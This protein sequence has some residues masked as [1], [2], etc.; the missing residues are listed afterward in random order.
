MN[1][2][3]LAAA[4]ILFAVFTDIQ[5]AN[6]KE[7]IIAP[8]SSAAMV[9]LQMRVVRLQLEHTE[10]QGGLTVE[11][12]ES[13]PSRV[14]IIVKLLPNAGYSTAQASVVSAT[15]ERP[16]E[17]KPF[18]TDGGLKKT[19]DAFVRGYAPLW[20]MQDQDRFIE[21]CLAALPAKGCEQS[22]KGVFVAI[23][24][25]SGERFRAEARPQ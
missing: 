22:V 6:A 11:T 21:N 19:I 24:P 2:A 15:M 14:R 3:M 9:Q 13:Q 12:W 20:P 5:A 8:S 17:D 25:I 10:K 1:K 16:L 7:K 18:K 4:M 23:N